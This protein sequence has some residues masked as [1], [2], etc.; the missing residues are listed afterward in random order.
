MEVPRLGVESE[1]QPLAYATATATWYLSHIC[2]L[3]H[4]SLQRQIRPTSSQILVR[5]V[6]LVNHRAKVGTH[7]EYLNL[8]GKYG[9][10]AQLVEYSPRYPKQTCM[11]LNPSLN[12]IFVLSIIY[13]FQKNHTYTYIYRNDRLTIN[14]P[15]YWEFTGDF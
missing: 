14:T 6:R 3:H 15:T 11:F 12:K 7:L 5:L 13:T 4:S 1:L 9:S 8:F 10:L 2:N